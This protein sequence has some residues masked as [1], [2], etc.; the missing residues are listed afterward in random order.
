VSDTQLLSIQ[1][2]FRKLVT[3]T[4]VW[5]YQG[6]WQSVL[7]APTNAVYCEEDT[8]VDIRFSLSG[9]TSW[10]RNLYFNISPDWYT[11]TNVLNEAQNGGAVL[12]R[13]YIVPKWHY[14]LCGCYIN[15]TSHSW[16]STITVYY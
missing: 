6:T 5:T 7:H 8:F 2:P 12:S 9:I 16:T 13:S 11:R 1:D 10:I 15:S 3:D 4:L 14:F